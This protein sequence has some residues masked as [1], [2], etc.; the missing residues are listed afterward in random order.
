MGLTLALIDLLAACTI[1]VATPRAEPETLLQVAFAWLGHAECVPPKNLIA[2]YF[3]VIH[4]MNGNTIGSDTHGPGN[5]GA[6]ASP[7]RTARAPRRRRAA[8]SPRPLPT[9]SG[10][11]ATGATPTKLHRCPETASQ[12]DGRVV[13]R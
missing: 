10:I 7:A 4:C 9:T 5:L 11:C 1:T 13:P 8:Q 2:P 12:G 3:V 6:F